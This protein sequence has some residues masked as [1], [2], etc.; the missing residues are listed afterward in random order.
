MW[1][2]TCY[3]AEKE[4]IEQEMEEGKYKEK[5]IAE[6]PKHKYIGETAR[7]T[8]EPGWEHQES[9]R[10]LEEDSHLLKHVANH[11]QGVPMDEILF[12]M[13]IVQYTRSALERQ[14]LESVLIQEEGKRHEIMNSKTN[15]QVG[16]Q[17]VQDRKEL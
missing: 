7:T 13:R 11:Y 15:N 17:G 1:C 6:I 12:G 4:K 14:V 16:G 10:K 8:Y 3:E 2:V 5:K 9:L